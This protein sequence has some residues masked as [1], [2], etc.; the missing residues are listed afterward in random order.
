MENAQQVIQHQAE[1]IAKAIALL[2]K[3]LGKAN[4]FKTQDA[5]W[6]DVSEVGMATGISVNVIAN[7]EEQE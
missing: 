1:T 7:Y 4:F 2:Q 3:E 5:T 6:R